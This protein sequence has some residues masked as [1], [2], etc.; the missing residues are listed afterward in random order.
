[1]KFYIEIEETRIKV[2]EVEAENSEEAI[3]KTKEA[4]KLDEIYMDD[5][6]YIAE[7]SFSDETCIYKGTFEFQEIS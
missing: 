5:V 1:M 4:Y 2:V 6:S 7:T 3:E